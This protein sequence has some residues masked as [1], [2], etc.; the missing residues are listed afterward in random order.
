MLLSFLIPMV[1]IAC[2]TILVRFGRDVGSRRGQ[3]RA[4]LRAIFTNPVVIACLL[5]L[6]LQQAA[7]A[8]PPPVNNLLDILGRAALPLGLLAVG[9]ALEPAII[10]HHSGSILSVTIFKL[11]LSP[12]LVWLFCLLFEVPPFTAKVAVIFAAL[13]GS[14]LSTI[15]ARQLGGD[16]PL[17]AGITTAQII[18]AAFTL[19]LIL[20]LL[21][22]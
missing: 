2:I 9:A 20:F 12:L 19:P 14:A 4:V 11:L 13:P 18:A 6:F 10:R 7:I 8:I 22:A 17:V 16:A 15:L 3:R 21:L 5:G 1:N